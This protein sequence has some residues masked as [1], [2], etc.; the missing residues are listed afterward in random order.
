Y[1]TVYMSHESRLIVESGG[2]LDMVN[3]RLI[4]NRAT[5][6]HGI[7]NSV[8]VRG[9]TIHATNTAFSTESE[10]ESWDGI[11]LQER[12]T[13][14]FNNCI[15]D[16][17]YPQIVVADGSDASVNNCHLSGGSIALLADKAALL[18]VYD[19]QIDGGINISSTAF[20]IQGNTIQAPAGGV[21]LDISWVGN[22]SA[23][24][25]VWDNSIIGGHVGIGIYNSQV[26]LGASDQA[27][28]HGNMILDN[29]V[30]ILIQN[31]S[32]ADLADNLI[33]DASS[34]YGLPE[35][36]LTQ[37]SDLQMRDGCNTVMDDIYDVGSHDQYLLKLLNSD[38]HRYSV[39][40]NWWGPY[41]YNDPDHLIELAGRFNPDGAFVSY[42]KVCGDPP[43][44][45]LP[46][47]EE[48]FAQAESAF[49]INDYQTATI[50]Y[51]QIIADYPDSEYAVISAKRLYAIENS[52]GQNYQELI[53]YYETV[54]DNSDEKPLKRATGHLVTQSYVKLESYSTAIDRLSEI[55]NNP[56]TFIDSIFAVIDRDYV[57]HMMDNN[58]VPTSVGGSDFIYQNRLATVRRHLEWKELAL[59][60][61]LDAENSRDDQESQNPHVLYPFGLAQN[62][63]NPFNPRTTIGFTLPSLARV[64]L[65]VYNSNGQLVR[66]LADSEFPAGSHHV[67]WSGE[68][69]L[70]Q[71]VGSGLYFYR[72][73][74]QDGSFDQTRKMIL[75]K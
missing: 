52:D 47:V 75:M 10:S 20:I 45:D 32:I 41:D 33:R 51:K 16:R 34:G 55:I 19:S 67:N 64:S 35:I 68:N 49:A 70:G 11:Q 58:A 7:G 48:L 66:A 29:T 42:S 13:G 31:N 57:Y 44:G 63:P 21:G 12:A 72:L 3:C 54:S 6:T 56:P 36:I 40:G 9:G 38:G 62:Y 69:D 50:L 1:S 4:S 74:T 23:H 14:M 22:M 46:P 60:L 53:A 43:D 61:L 8:M 39:D 2:V 18:E 37:D 65:K 30:G 26:F 15:F 27:P 28:E 17:A 5:D 59:S 24:A 25:R 71:T 73:R